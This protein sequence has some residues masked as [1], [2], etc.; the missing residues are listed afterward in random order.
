VIIVALLGLPG[1][2]SPAKAE[3]VEIGRSAEVLDGG[4][5]MRAGG[6]LC[7]EGGRADLGLRG[8]WEVRPLE[9]ELDPTHDYFIWTFRG[10]IHPKG[11]EPVRRVKA[12]LAA[13][14][15]ELGQWDPAADRDVERA[16][17]VEA[18]LRRPDMTID[19]PFQTLPGRIHPY[20]DDHL[21][22]ISWIG[23][24]RPVTGDVEVGTVTVWVVPEGQAAFTAEA[25]LQAELAP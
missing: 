3:V 1:C 4:T 10:G 12:R 5:P 25:S 6:R 21:F 14:G 13:N 8:C 18:S 16:G 19:Y 24:G 2:S 20:P 9:S 11:P 15:A 22:H 7:L 17:Q 23:T